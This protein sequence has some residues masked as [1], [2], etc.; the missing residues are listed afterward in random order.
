MMIHIARADIGAFR[1]DIV[2]AN[3]HLQF[4]SALHVFEDKE[5][6]A[7]H[8]QNARDLS[9]TMSEYTDCPSVNVR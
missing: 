2:N 9:E 5:S 8:S 6:P 1:S 3:Y 4:L 7:Q